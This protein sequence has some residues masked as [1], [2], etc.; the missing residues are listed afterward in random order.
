M[1]HDGQRQSRERAERGLGLV[2]IDRALPGTGIKLELSHFLR[3]FKD[4]Y[5]PI[6]SI[7]S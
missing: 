2:C 1:G 7:F 5:S 4:F 3:F 6:T